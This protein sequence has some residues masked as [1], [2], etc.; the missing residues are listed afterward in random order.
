M[1]GVLK[2]DVISN[3]KISYNHNLLL[4]FMPDLLGPGKR[5]SKIIELC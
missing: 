5:A 2:S 3:F 1:F 4:Y